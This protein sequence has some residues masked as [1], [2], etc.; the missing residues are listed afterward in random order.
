VLESDALMPGKYPEH[1]IARPV[2]LQ[3]WAST[4][5]I[6][7]RLSPD[8][9]QPLL[10]SPLTPQVYDGTAWVSLVPLMLSDFRPAVPF[11]RRGITFPEINL[12]TYVVHP[13]GRAGLWF[14]TIDAGNRPF[15]WAART[16]LGAP[17][18]P[19]DVAVDHGDDTIRFTS[20][21]SGA[22]SATCDVRLSMGE[23][24]EK[25]DRLALH[26]SLAG[27]WRAFTKRVGV[28]FDVS[29]E[30]EPWP[31]R[32]AELLSFDERYFEL[33]GLQ[34]P[35]GPPLVQFADAVNVRMA[36]PMPARA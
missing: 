4:A 8:E 33:V 3:R 1:H 9:L 18:Y 2:M 27:Q 26:D 6:H 12:R 32:H 10:P 35:T 17:Y 34:R 36:L 25:P 29:I 16:F 14:L 15:S 31:L 24:I 13:N 23:V 7:W 30:H 19:A 20:R 21:R 28:L 5:F 22:D 11:M